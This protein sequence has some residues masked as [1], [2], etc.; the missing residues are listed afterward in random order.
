M[1][2]VVD[3]NI[4]FS[5]FWKGSNTKKI[6][7]KPDFDLYTPMFF[8]KELD[9]YKGEVISRTKISNEQFKEFKKMLSDVVRFASENEYVEFIEESKHISPD[10]KDVD[11]LAL[12]LK[13]NCPLWSIDKALKKQPKVKV[14]ST[15]ELIEEF[16]IKL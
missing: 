9:K 13:L 7:L 4:L 5:F 14:Y 8:F 15:S 16:E 3:S 2:F 1:K 12:A 10:L 11:F 6:I